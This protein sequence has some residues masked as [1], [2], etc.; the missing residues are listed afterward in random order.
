MGSRCRGGGHRHENKGLSIICR[1][2]TV[3]MAQKTGSTRRNHFSMQI[4]LV[5]RRGTPLP[6]RL[7]LGCSLGRALPSAC[8]AL[9][10]PTLLAA[11]HTSLQKSIM[12]PKTPVRWV[13]I[14]PGNDGCLERHHLPSSPHRAADPM[15]YSRPALTLLVTCW[16]RRLDHR[17]VRLPYST[18]FSIPF[19]PLY[20]TPLLK[21]PT[22]APS[23]LVFPSSSPM[24]PLSPLS[25]LLR[26]SPLASP[27]RKRVQ[28]LVTSAKMTIATN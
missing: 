18:S 22:P 12:I 1:P 23:L 10:L 16:A 19:F 26:P 6:A 20:Y 24:V 2:A 11:S 13:I 9:R 5:D 27:E 3:V 21:P 28:A 14:S 15:T 25:L 8:C 7:R 17:Q 4:G